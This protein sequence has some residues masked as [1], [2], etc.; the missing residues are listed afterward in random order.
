MNLR[1]IV[2]ALLAA[3]STAAAQSRATPAPAHATATAPWEYSVYSTWIG[4]GMRW[5]APTGEVTGKGRPGEFL[6][7]LG[8][9]P[10]EIPHKH[11]SEEAWDAAALN[12]LGRQGWEL[13]GC[14]M[15]ERTRTYHRT[16]YLKRPA[17]RPATAPAP[18]PP[19]SP[20]AR[21]R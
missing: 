20:P 3:S 13:V 6:E 4:S 7:A 12:I 2:A 15:I 1:V 11:A 10:G 19:P 16:C 21:D 17:A 18:E 8:A 5:V 9:A 14:N